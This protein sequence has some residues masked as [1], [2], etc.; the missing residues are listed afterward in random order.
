M[1]VICA[2]S[3]VTALRADGIALSPDGITW[4]AGAGGYGNGWGDVGKGI[5]I[6]AGST[7]YVKYY[8]EA[9]TGLPLYHAPH[10]TKWGSWAAAGPALTGTIGDSPENPVI[11]RFENVGT[12]KSNA[13]WVN[14]K[15]TWMAF[16]IA[17]AYDIGLQSD[18]K[19]TLPP[20][21]IHGQATF[22][23]WFIGL[24]RSPNSN[25]ENTEG[26]TSVP[27]AGQTGVLLAFALLGVALVWWFSSKR[28]ARGGQNTAGKAD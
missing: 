19:W 27:D 28:R 2:A 25:S 15:G 14:G 21:T 8:S 9:R 16:P 26:T 10:G 23:S 24:L 5:K 20:I 11:L 22:K 6:K 4:L 12:G 3:G 1:L 7:L 17:G 13:T 18:S